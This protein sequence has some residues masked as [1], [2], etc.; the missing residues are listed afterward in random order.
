MR[1]A[2]YLSLPTD[3]SIDAFIVRL[4]ESDE[5][6]RRKRVAEYV[7]PREV[8]RQ[9]DG[10][11]K[12]VGERL[13]QRRDVGRFLYGSS[14]SGKSHMM[15]VLA[16]MLSR[17]KSVDA[18]GEWSPVSRARLRRQASKEAGRFLFGSSVMRWRPCRVS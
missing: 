17:D 5:V 3:V 15:L 9:L 2:D 11:L 14:G 12:V 1:V 16:R 6:L 18:E 13:T 4:D 10:M 7:L 8:A